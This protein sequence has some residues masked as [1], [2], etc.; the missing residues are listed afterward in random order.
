MR[1]YPVFPPTATLAAPWPRSL[2]PSLR[3][4]TA[5]RARRFQLCT[6]LFWLLCEEFGTASWPDSG[7]LRV[8]SIALLLLD[9]ALG[10][11]AVQTHSEL[12]ALATLACYTALLVLLT[13][14]FAVSHPGS[15]SYA[16]QR[17]ESELGS[18][19]ARL[20]WTADGCMLMSVLGWV[21]IGIGYASALYAWFMCACYWQLVRAAGEDARVLRRAIHALPVL[22]HSK[23]KPLPL[24]DG[25]ELGEV[26]TCAICLDDFEEGEE[27]RLLPCVHVYHKSC[28]DLWIRRQGLDASC[29]V[30][31][32]ALIRGHGA[33]PAPAEAEV[34][35]DTAPV[36]ET[37]V[38]APA[39]GPAA[40]PQPARSGAA[41]ACADGLGVPLMSEDGAG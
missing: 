16:T 38:E 14:G 5:C 21:T 10:W 37:D 28:I 4:R 22:R 31:K 13:A 1:P 12:A 40:Q 11:T 8:A 19:L 36:A 32:Q 3:A 41:A 15:C 34:D 26:S 33:P 30:C 25:R 6:G 18:L 29:P 39:A 9:A 2:A 23:D 27:L 20:L 17:S 7:G 35:G 24:I